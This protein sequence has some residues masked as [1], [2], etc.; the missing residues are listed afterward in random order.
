M[1]KIIT[2]I[3]C[4]V[5][6]FSLTSCD[7]FKL[8]N[9]D[10]WDAQVE[11]KIVDQGTG[12]PI[13]MEQGN[14]IQV[15]ELYGSQYGYTHGKQKDENGN[16]IAGW[17][18]TSSISWAVKND[19]TFVNKLTFAGKYR[20]EPA[21][22]NFSAEK[23]FFELKKGSNTVEFKATPYVRIKN[24][25]PSWD[26]SKIN[27]S[28]DVEAAVAGT[29][30]SRVEI[31][32]FPD[33]WVRHSQNNCQYDS[34]AYKTNPTETSFSLSVDSKAPANA[35]EFQYDRIHYF[36]VAALGSNPANSSNAYNY[37]AVYKLE[38]GTITEVTDW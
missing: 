12:Q 21:G 8:D 18:G 11:G 7:W 31:C 17:D 2:L 36:R 5:A 9:L 26:G 28:F 1:K 4:I 16:E 20:F 27:V 30:I 19:G 10:G 29:R 37:S 32:V 15:Y 23:Q 24:V 22:G 13:Q 6:L 33:R 14:N 25:K 38:K 3:S 34:G 35:N